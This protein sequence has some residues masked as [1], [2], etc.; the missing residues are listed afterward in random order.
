MLFYPYPTVP[1]YVGTVHGWQIL[2]WLLQHYHFV[3]DWDGVG[4][5]L[6]YGLEHVHT[7]KPIHWMVK[8]SNKLGMWE[9]GGKVYHGIIKVQW[10]FNLDESSSRY[11][12]ARCT[13]TGRVVQV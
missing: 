11:I 9:I 1:T 5:L 4:L 12:S 6:Y 8:G 10:T 7:L 3:V 13:P 2:P